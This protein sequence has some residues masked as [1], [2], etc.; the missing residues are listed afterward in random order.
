MFD[1]E[2][3]TT[4]PSIFTDKWKRAVLFL[5]L[6]TGQQWCWLLSLA[7]VLHLA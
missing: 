7:A 3:D 1:P 6:L 2:K 4:F 5:Q